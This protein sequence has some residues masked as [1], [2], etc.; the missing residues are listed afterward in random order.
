MNEKVSKINQNVNSEASNTQKNVN[1]IKENIDMIKRWR[2]WN[3]WCRKLI[4]I[5]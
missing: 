2:F 4:Q 5:K 3:L 1:E